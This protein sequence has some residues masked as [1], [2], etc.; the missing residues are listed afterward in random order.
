MVSAQVFENILLDVVDKREEGWVGQDLKSRQ[1]QLV[2]VLI[3]FPSY[4]P[5]SVER[6][7]G[8]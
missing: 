3:D 6:A 7:L 8:K 2:H 4:P 1:C 5:E